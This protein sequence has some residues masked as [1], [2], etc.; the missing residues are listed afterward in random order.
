MKGLHVTKWSSIKL[1]IYNKG[2]QMHTNIDDQNYDTDTAQ[3]I[4]NKTARSRV[5]IPPA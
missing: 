2:K 1:S 3:T 5:Q 4:V